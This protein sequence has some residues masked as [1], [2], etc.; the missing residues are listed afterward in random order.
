MRFVN[1]MVVHFGRQTQFAPISNNLCS[2]TSINVLNRE[3]D[4]LSQ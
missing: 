3:M 4:G 2:R 1:D